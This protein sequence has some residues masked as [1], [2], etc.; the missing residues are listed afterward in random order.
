MG[1]G[2]SIMPRELNAEELTN[3]MMPPYYIRNV[4]VTDND[5]ILGRASWKKVADGSSASYMA[6]KDK[7]D[8]QAASCLTWFYDSFYKRLF[9]VNPSARPLFKNNLMSQGRVLMGI[10]STA[11]NQLKEPETFTQMLINL[12]HTHSHRGVRGMQYGIAGDVLFW[13]LNKCLGPT[14][15]DDATA[16]SWINIFSYMLSIIVP[17]AVED[18][19]REIE[20]IRRGV[21]PSNLDLTKLPTPEDKQILETPE[22]NRY[23]IK[24]LISGKY[25]KSSRYDKK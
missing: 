19:I 15:F 18:E 21:L 23:E 20:L 4:I 2:P 11:L 1:S 25:D 3:L 7:P 16:K 12:A 24:D 14:D 17:V 10:I 13:T 8:F 9:D 22:I 5:I 6:E